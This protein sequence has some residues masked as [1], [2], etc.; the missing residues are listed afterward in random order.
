MT[1][2]Y[3]RRAKPPV[4][5]NRAL[6]SI[7]ASPTEPLREDVRRRIIGDVQKAVESVQAG[8]ANGDE[9]RRIVDCVNMVHEFSSESGEFQLS[10]SIEKE[11]SAALKAI[12][13]MSERTPLHFTPE[14]VHD[15]NVVIEIFSDILESAPQREVIRVERIV[16]DTWNKCNNAI[17]NKPTK[18]KSSKSRKK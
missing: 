15:V 16:V 14:E 11:H 5:L 6:L 4:P 7:V 18:K 17:H 1:T 3:R 10:E 13:A 2:F 12:V 8:T 9:W